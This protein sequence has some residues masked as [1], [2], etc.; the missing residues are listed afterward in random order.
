MEGKERSRVLET[1]VR[2][3]PT[4]PGRA[5]QRRGAL[6]ERCDPGIDST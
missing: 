3:L 6:I 1:N 5:A 4:A 2:T